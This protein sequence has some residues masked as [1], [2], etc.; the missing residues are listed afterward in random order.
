MKTST[1]IALTSTTWGKHKETL[2]VTYKTLTRPILEY[3]ATIYGPIIKPTLTNKLQKIQNVALRT[4]TGCTADTNIQHLHDETEILPIAHHCRLHTSILRHKAQYHDHTLYPLTLQTDPPRLMKQTAFHNS[5]F[6]TNLPPNNL[7]S[8][9]QTIHT[10]IVQNYLNSRQPSK[11]ANNKAP[12]PNKI[13][14]TLPRETR[15]QL[16]ELR[17]DKSPLLYSYLNKIDPAK[18][19]TDTCPLCTT[20]RYD[21]THLFNCPNIPTALTVGD[22]W[23]SLVEVSN[24]LGRW[25]EAFGRLEA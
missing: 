2:L 9:I 19:P 14:Q 18:H 17:T 23:T 22:L 5:N 24:L 1:D 4:A 3:G 13:E 21:A 10:E 12:P 8:N 25:R 20:K 16:A 7:K 15:R 11:L 6:T